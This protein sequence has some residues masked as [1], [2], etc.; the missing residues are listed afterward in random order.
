MI[1]WLI[2]QAILV[3]FNWVN[4]RIDAYRI[5]KD[6][7]IAHGINFGSYAIVTAL[8]IWLFRYDLLSGITFGVSA[9]TNRQFSFD[10]PLNK[11][12]GKPWDYVS[13]DKPPKA[14]M[15]RIEIALFGYNG[16]A[17]FV[18]YGLVWIICT[19]IKWIWL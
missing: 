4:S 17:P 9:F 12:R 11:R 10:I 8:L 14:L 3:V 1:T 13:L 6:K 19:L 16:R 18:L 2:N 5:V 7:T 15:D